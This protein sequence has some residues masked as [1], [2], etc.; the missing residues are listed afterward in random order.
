MIKNLLI[1]LCLFAITAHAQP[2]KTK[3]KTKTKVAKVDSTGAPVEEEPP[4][5]PMEALEATLPLEVELD[6]MTGKKVIHKDVKRRNDSL[7]AD[8]RMK[9]RKEVTDFWVRTKYPNPKAKSPEKIQLCFNIV[10]K[11]TNLIHCVN[12][13][14]VVDPEVKKVLFEKRNGDSTYM[15]IF[16]DAFSKLKNDGGLCGAGH[17]TK[18]YFV[19]W[20]TKTNQAKWKTKHIASCS[21]GITNMTKEP[22]AGWDK[23]APLIVKYNRSFYFYEIKFDPAN[24]QL[25]IQTVKD[26]AAKEGKAE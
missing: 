25:G 18:L 24:P 19:R 16:V 21:K 12:D 8:L 1:V 15:L 22:I 9:I 3:S 7:R 11:D 26:D 2:G 23:A 4:L 20:N 5:D 17:E 10:S 14:L 6:P 13:S